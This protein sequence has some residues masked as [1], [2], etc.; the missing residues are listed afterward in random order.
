[1]VA[2]GTTVLLRIIQIDWS[3]LALECLSRGADPHALDARRYSAL[4]WAVIKDQPEVVTALLELGVD[5]E[6]R[7]VNDL[8]PLDFAWRCHNKRMIRLLELGR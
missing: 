6:V 3:D 2:A 5:T 4:H 7:T 1:M 8:C